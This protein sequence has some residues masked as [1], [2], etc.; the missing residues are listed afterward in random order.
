MAQPGMP[1][2]MFAIYHQF[3]AKIQ[4]VQSAPDQKGSIGTMPKTAEKK[5]EH[6]IAQGNCG[7][8]AAAPQGDVYIIRKPPGQ[9]DVPAPPNA[10][11]VI[12]E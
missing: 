10:R 3:Q 5:D 8:S 6:R 11:T 9:G 1:E 4:T 7:A 12:A 2:G